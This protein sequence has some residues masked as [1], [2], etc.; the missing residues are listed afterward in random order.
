MSEEKRRDMSQQDERGEVEGRVE[1]RKSKYSPK[2]CCLIWKMVPAGPIQKEATQTNT[3]SRKK[4]L[5]M[6]EGGPVSQPH[7]LAAFLTMLPIQQF[8]SNNYI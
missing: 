6:E 5:F 4:H 2:P 1:K 3:E 8:K 7:L